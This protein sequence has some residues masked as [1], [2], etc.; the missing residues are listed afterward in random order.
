MNSSYLLEIKAPNPFNPSIIVCL[1]T[2]PAK[3]AISDQARSVKLLLCRTP[4]S[5]MRRQ[6]KKKR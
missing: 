6:S 2:S 4:A 3:Q 1:T 5:L